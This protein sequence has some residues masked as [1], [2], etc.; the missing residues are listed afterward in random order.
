MERTAFTE[1]KRWKERPNRKP[2]IIQG[3]RQVGKTWLMREFGKNFYR[4]TA[5]LNFADT[6]Q[7]AALFE[8]RYDVSSII[9]GIEILCN[10]EIQADD[11]LIILDEIQECE[12]ALNSLKFLRYCLLRY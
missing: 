10:C 12:R 3:A 2:L 11:T 8:G 7:A 1:L 4:T 6:P 5:Y 9:Q